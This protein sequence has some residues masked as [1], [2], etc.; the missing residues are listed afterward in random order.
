MAVPSAS[1]RFFPSE[2]QRR[3]LVL[4][5]RAEWSGEAGREKENGQPT[6]DVKAPEPAPG[7]Q[8]RVWS[9]GSC[10]CGGGDEVADE[11]TAVRR[12][13]AVVE[14]AD[15]GGGYVDAGC[16]GCVWLQGLQVSLG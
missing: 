14:L 10:C 1:A 4:R 3:G 7:E 13:D 6:D 5:T 15:H 16:G 9:K 8:V 11:G 12:G 2:R